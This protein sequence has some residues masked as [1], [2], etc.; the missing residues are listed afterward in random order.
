MGIKIVKICTCC[1][2]QIPKECD[3]KEYYIEN[4]GKGTTLCIGGMKE[5]KTL[6]IKN[7]GLFYHFVRGFGEEWDVP[8]FEK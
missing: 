1:K 6:R 3:G 4:W 5:E 2:K 8:L 7:G